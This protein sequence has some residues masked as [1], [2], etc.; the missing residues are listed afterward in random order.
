MM[1]YITTLL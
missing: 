1:H